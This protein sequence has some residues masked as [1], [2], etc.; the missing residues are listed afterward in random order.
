MTNLVEVSIGFAIIVVGEE[1]EKE[2]EEEEE[3]EE[4]REVAL[5][6]SRIS[7]FPFQHILV[8]ECFS[9]IDVDC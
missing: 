2:E 4:K 1:T 3:E 8:I 5:R 9:K 6:M 7:L